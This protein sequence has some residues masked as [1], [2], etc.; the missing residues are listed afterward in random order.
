MFDD[1]TLVQFRPT[2]G[3]VLVSL[4]TVGAFDFGW[5]PLI[6]GDRS[7]LLI[8]ANIELDADTYCDRVGP[9]LVGGMDLHLEFQ[10]IPVPERGG[11]A[12]TAAALAA[13]GLLALRRSCA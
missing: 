10:I 2:P 6:V 7:T 9:F 13:L 3:F 12:G 11:A 4:D 8:A 5:I 1:D